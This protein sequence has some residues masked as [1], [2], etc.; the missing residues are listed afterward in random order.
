MTLYQY[1]PLENPSHIRLIRF[2][3]SSPTLRLQL[4]HAP[5][6]ENESFEALSYTWGNTD[7]RMPVNIGDTILT[8][9]PNL[10]QFL[11]RLREGEQADENFGAY[12]A[13]QICINQKDILERNSQVALMASIYRTS[14]RTL[15]WLGEARFRDATSL[16]L[17]G[18]IDR[19]GF[20]K[21]NPLRSVLPKVID[22]IELHL[23]NTSPAGV[24][25]S[26]PA[27]GESSILDLM[28][29]AW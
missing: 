7:Q 12:W 25:T 2:D 15:V 10:Y 5:L 29:R 13:D 22:T 11:S 16:R 28:N 4:I 17:L 9:T 24:E 26:D 20:T 21:D 1:L 23:T 27:E 3:H 14:R 8:I 19:R 18:D 6:N